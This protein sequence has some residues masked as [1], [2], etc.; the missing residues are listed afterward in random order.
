MPRAH[1]HYLPGHVWHITH[2]CHDREFLL[3]AK[4]D[5]SQWRHKLYEAK[6]RY[7]LSVLNFVV[8]SNHIHLLVY[9]AAG[10]DSISRGLQ[11]LQGGTAQ[12]YNRRRGRRGAF[13]QDRYHA[14]AVDTDS[15]LWRCLVYL[16]LNMVRAGVV[17]HPREW[18][19]GGYR[20]IEAPRSR[21]RV[22]DLARLATLTGCS[23]VEV[24]RA[25]HIELVSATLATRELVREPIWTEMVA[26]GERRF[27]EDIRG[28]LGLTRLQRIGTD[29]NGHSTLREETPPYKATPGTKFAG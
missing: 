18:C 16:D 20:E 11:Y 8:T 17:S 10:D 28:R 21:Y 4:L 2:R 5:R 14:V 1:R 3:N 19:D 13:W 23:S 22:L 15:Y 27:V 24:F 29:D 25:R 7:E 26:V 12:A 9:D 6:V